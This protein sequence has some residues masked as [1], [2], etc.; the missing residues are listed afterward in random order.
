MRIVA[1]SLLAAFAVPIA[2][3]AFQDPSSFAQEVAAGLEWRSIGPVNTSGRVDDIAVAQRPGD[4][5][6]VYV[7]TASGGIFKS[8][9]A[10]ISWTPV[11]DS[12]GG[13]M[14]IG[15]IAVAPSNPSVVWAGTG[16]SN[17][18]Q[19]SSWGDGVY[20]STDSGATWIRAG[21]ADTR[22]IGR[23][24][25][26]PTNPNVVYVAA[27]GHLW[28]SNH[29]RGVFKTTDGGETWKQV[30]YVNDDTGANDIVIDPS[31]P[32][33]LYAAAYQRQRKSWG[34]NGG[35]PGSGVYK[36][37]DAGE[38]WTRLTN[39]LPPGDKGRIGLAM[40]D[41]SLVYAVIEAATADKHVWEGLYVTTDEGATWTHLSASNPRPSYF[42]QIRPDPADR[43][44]VYQLGS[45]RGFLVSLD[46][47]AT[48]RDTGSTGLHGED[49]ALWID[50]HD[51]NHLIVGGDGGV[52]ISRDRGRTWD[53]RM[54][55][56]I[57]QFYEV[58]VDAK[59]PFT[60][61]GGLQDNGEWCVPSAVRNRY[62][63]S[64]TDA[65]NIGGGD[66]FY[67]KFDPTD[68]NFVY[69]ESQDGGMSRVN[70]MTMERQ[71]IKPRGSHRWNW[72]TPIVV[73]AA[74]PKTIYTGAEVVFRS[75]DRG[76]SWQVISP[77]LTA[78]VDPDSLPIMGRPNPAD[79]LSR[80]DGTSPL[81]S[82]TTISESPLNPQVLYTGAQDG[83]IQVT[84][85]GGRTW[86]NLTPRLTGIPPYTYVSSV[87][88]SRHAAGRVYA[89]LDG[90]YNDDYRPYVFVSDDYG[91][92]WTSLAESLEETSINRIREHP[93]DAR[94]LFLAHERGI[95]FSIDEGRRWMP[96]SGVAGLP[97]TP[98]DDIAIHP[99]DNALV[100]GTHGRG[101]W[102]LDDA[103]PLELAAEWSVKKEPLLAPI[104]PAVALVTHLPQAWFGQGTFFAPN[105]RYGAAISYVLAAATSTVQVEIRSESGKLVR[106][107]S[108]TGAPG[109]NSVRWDLRVVAP[110]DRRANLNNAPLAPAGKYE[111][112]VRIA[113]VPHELHGVLTVSADPLAT[114]H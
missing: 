50:P 60:I 88:A 71:S 55:M 109:L 93:T 15:A 83:T 86:T 67:V 64:A 59:M 73:S 81:G 27:L 21:L 65:W 3:G 40:F 42:S 96:L 14:S 19:S 43:L 106:S 10:G 104:A 94:L 62:G 80:N 78:H 91:Q 114:R 53:F 95:H 47:G 28:G 17:G 72:D 112:V 76:T 56:P 97:N 90:H 26:H 6:V 107:L 82:L 33:V 44:R 20:K 111:V 66:G 36:S 48:F 25:I 108:G 29:E 16:E 77:D 75:R 110:D 34:F 87:L 61:C 23:I 11:F 63:I 113:G 12:S 39:G 74:D 37:T 54:N 99:R 79:A 102:V 8:A 9:N 68:W 13:M 69:A 31:N 38:H 103:G 100:L 2:N 98:I 4:P 57:G 22:H 5:D 18:R 46:G 105:P 45:N 41:H 58:D 35:G 30:L 85:N 70:I 92:T 1:L 7:A 84:R 52:A 51:S 24:V 32:S 49:H 89:T 101:I